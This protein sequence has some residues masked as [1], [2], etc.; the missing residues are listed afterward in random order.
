MVFNVFVTKIIMLLSLE[1]NTIPRARITFISLHT[2]HAD[3][4]ANYVQ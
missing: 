1:I 3:E 4:A 2:F